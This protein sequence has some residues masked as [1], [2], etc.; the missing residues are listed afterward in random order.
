MND[1]DI[2]K[3]LEFCES[4]DCEC[5]SWCP[6][7]YNGT[8][9]KSD[10]R[11]KLH[12]NALD[13]IDR[14]KTELLAVKEAWRKS[15]MDYIDLNAEWE[16]KYKTAK[17]EAIKEFAKRAKDKLDDPRTF[18]SGIVVDVIM[19]YIDSLVKEMTEGEDGNV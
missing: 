17:A 14:L 12:K 13:L 6:M 5:T 18:G 15:G 2:I 11:G 1:N 16:G 4:P 10:C 3:A 9:S 8:N 7:F 19:D